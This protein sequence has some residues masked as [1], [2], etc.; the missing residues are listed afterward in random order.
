[1]TPQPR[2]VAVSVAVPTVGRL[3]MLRRCLQS[4]AAGTVEPTELLVLDQ[5]TDV[6]LQSELADLNIGY[7][8]VVRCDGKGIARNL[9]MALETASQDALAITHDD[10]SVAPDWLETMERA[11]ESLPGGL[12]SGRVLPPE[13][14]D[15]KRVPSINISEVPHEYTGTIVTHSIMAGNMVF[16]RATARKIGGFDER[17]GFRTAAEDTDFG[18]RWLLAG[19]PMRYEPA[20][21]V[22]HY[23]WREGDDLVSL[24][25]H[26]SRCVGRFY[27]KHLVE[28]DWR[29]AGWIARDMRY[30]LRARKRHLL[31]ESE[32]WEEDCLDLPLYLPIGVAEGLVESV[33]IKFANRDADK[34]ITP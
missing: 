8:R 28:G 5:S 33:R 12:I 30:G 7:L 34:V 13:G 24:Y 29:M 17:D 26:Y 16:S 3:D 15:P 23:D 22:T 1:M 25:R 9:N 19:H 14:V 20:A 4:V 21:V 11:I 27:A 6:D 31:G 2:R 32:R 18:Y 10:C